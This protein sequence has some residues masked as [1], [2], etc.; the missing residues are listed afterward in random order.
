MGLEGGDFETI[1]KVQFDY[2][3][4]EI[5]F[6]VDEKPGDFKTKMEEAKTTGFLGFLRKNGNRVIVQMNKVL[7]ME[8]GT[9]VPK[10]KTKLEPPETEE[11]E[12]DNKE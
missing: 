6:F 2:Q 4:S 12:P 10:T 5:D 3:E 7:W 11:E 9:R 8:V 1:L